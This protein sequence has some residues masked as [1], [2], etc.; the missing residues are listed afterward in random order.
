MF[1]YKVQGKAHWLGLGAFADYDLAEVREAARA[2]RRQIRDGIDP[3]LAKREEKAAKL[4]AADTTFKAVAEQYIAT[5]KDTWRNPK[6]AAQWPSTLQAYVFPIIGDKPVSS[7]T[8][9]DVL[10]VLEPIWRAKPE[11]ASRIRGR[12]ETIL[13]FATARNFRFGDNPARW[14]GHLEHS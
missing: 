7:V 2:C 4:R 13:D 14:R 8:V 6:H 10:N 12:I 9:T 3:I 11:T 1:R 5:H